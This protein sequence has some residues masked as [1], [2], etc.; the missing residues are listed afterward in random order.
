MIESLAG[1]PKPG[2]RVAYVENRAEVSRVHVKALHNMSQA[3]GRYEAAARALAHERTAL[4]LS[5]QWTIIFKKQLFKSCSPA[6]EP[7]DRSISDGMFQSLTRAVG[8][9]SNS[10]WVPATTER[11]D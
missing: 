2:G 10:E 7:K 1:V 4:T 8:V 5:C 9:S 3:H 6:S 11:P